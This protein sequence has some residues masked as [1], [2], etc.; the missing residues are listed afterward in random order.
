MAGLTHA[1]IFSSSSV[2]VSVSGSCPAVIWG[3]GV[4]EPCVSL[5][6]AGE[7]GLFHT[8][9]G[10]GSKRTSKR[11]QGLLRLGLRTGTGILPH[12]FGQSKS[13]D[14]KGMREAAKLCGHG[15]CSERS[16]H[17]WPRSPATTRGTS[18]TDI[19]NVRNLRPERAKMFCPNYAARKWKS[20][21]LNS[22][23]SMVDCIV[24]F[25]TLFSRRGKQQGPCLAQSQT[26]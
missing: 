3:T 10:Q 15:S 8:A 22:E 13:P 6:P 2:N 20:Q 26:A 24:V 1:S 18:I 23:V 16:G 7:L 19:L 12:S 5:R 21:D 14:F 25:K 9:A 4:T 11:V 17:L